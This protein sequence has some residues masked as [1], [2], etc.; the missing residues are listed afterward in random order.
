MPTPP[1]FDSQPRGIF[2]AVLLL[3]SLV[4]GPTDPY[5]PAIPGHPVFPAGAASLVTDVVFD[6]SA[7]AALAAADDWSL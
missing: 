1:S 5:V 2:E 4:F 7:G 6:V 3:D